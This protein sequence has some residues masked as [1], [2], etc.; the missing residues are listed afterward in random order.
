[1]TEFSFFELSNTLTRHN[2]LVK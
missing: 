2:L 1:M